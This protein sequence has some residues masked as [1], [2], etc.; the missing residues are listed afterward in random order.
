MKIKKY[1]IKVKENTTIIEFIVPSIIWLL[2]NIIAGYW[3]LEYLIECNMS[4]V[5]LMVI[6]IIN[7]DISYISSIVN[8][9][10]FYE[11]YTGVEL[12]EKKE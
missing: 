2:L 11:E 6:S 9:I 7:V 4:G 5:T 8:K 10:N 3:L 12:D 1:R